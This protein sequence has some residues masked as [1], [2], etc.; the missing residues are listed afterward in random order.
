MVPLTSS[1]A[2]YFECA[3]GLTPPCT[4]VHYKPTS[5]P[6]VYHTLEELPRASPGVQPAPPSHHAGALLKRRACKAR[7]LAGESYDTFDF[8]DAF[9]EY[10]AYADAPINDFA[11]LAYA[12]HGRGTKV[13]LTVRDAHSWAARRV[14]FAGPLGRWSLAA[15]QGLESWLFTR[16]L[17]DPRSLA[18]RSR[19]ERLALTFHL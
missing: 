13:V 4:K 17:K 5:F 6:P 1:Q 14:C 10:D 15:L 12:A 11:T 9:S 16:A 7:S 2:A 19:S 18:F 8:C 3:D